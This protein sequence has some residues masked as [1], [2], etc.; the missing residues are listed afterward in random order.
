VIKIYLWVGRV[1][2]VS[3]KKWNWKCSWKNERKFHLKVVDTEI[4]LQRVLETVRTLF[5][6]TVSMWVQ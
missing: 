4:V 1:A 3:C 5:F 2:R 6:L